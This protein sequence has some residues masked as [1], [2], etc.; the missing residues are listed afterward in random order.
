MEDF[1]FSVNAV[2]PLFILMAVG[3]ILTRLNVWNS[4]FLKIAN[5]ISFNIL[6][7]CNLFCNIYNANFTEVFDAKLLSFVLITVAVI[8]GIG[9]AVVPV[10][11]KKPARQGVILQALFRGNFALLGLPLCEALAGPEGAQIASVFLAFLIPAFN[12]LATVILSIYS[13]NKPDSIWK[14]LKNIAKNPLIIGCVAGLLFSFTKPYF[15]LPNIVYKPLSDLKLVATPFALLVLGGDFKFRSFVDNI[16]CVTFTGLTRTVVVP[17]IAVVFAALLGFRGLHIALIISTFGTPVAV[18]STAM[19]YKMNG[20][21]DLACQVVVFTTL[22][23]AF[24][25]TMFAFISRLS[26]LL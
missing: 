11:S 23:S 14:I 12:I 10:L 24:T 15:T 4:D 25:I 13:D 17:A 19:T 8:V 16:K 9:F 26:G 7:P 22:C 2:I 18:A 20:D 21:Y 6:I 5:T 3:W 1:L